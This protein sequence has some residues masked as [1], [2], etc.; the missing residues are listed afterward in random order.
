MTVVATVFLSIPLVGYGAYCYWLNSDSLAHSQLQDLPSAGPL[1]FV[2]ST[3]IDATPKTGIRKRMLNSFLSQHKL[4]GMEKAKVV[5]LLGRFDQSW[6]YGYGET[7][8]ILNQSDSGT[9]TLLKLKIEN[10][11]VSAQSVEDFKP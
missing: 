1:D 3:W 10:G 2:R 4:V 6:G 11:C 8:Y 9:Q 5:D 7:G